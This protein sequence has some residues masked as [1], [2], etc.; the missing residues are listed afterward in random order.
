MQR[1]IGCLLTLLFL[2]IWLTACSDEGAS[3]PMDDLE[4]PNPYENMYFEGYWLQ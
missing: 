1:K 2:S 3:I 4:R